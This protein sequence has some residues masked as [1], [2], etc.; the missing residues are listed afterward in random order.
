MKEGRL[1]QKK[2]GEKI[3]YDAG[4]F[5]INIA[6]AINIDTFTSIFDR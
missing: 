6:A 4:D 2:F 1:S 3:R 5:E